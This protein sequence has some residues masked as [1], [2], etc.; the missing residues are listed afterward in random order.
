MRS[1]GNITQTASVGIED[2]QS[3][4]VSVV[5]TTTSATALMESVRIL[6]IGIVCLPASD[7]NAGTFSFTWYGERGPHNTETMIYSQ[8]VPSRWIFYPPEESL[9]SFWI[10][11][12]DDEAAV[13]LFTLGA[14]NATVEIIMDIHFE[15]V[16]L[17]GA[18]DKAFTLSSAATF[19]GIGA[20][21]LANVFNPVALS[22]VSVL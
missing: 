6:S 20:R 8:G 16:V 9:A 15:Y 17:D 21:I 12:S 5:D 1:S 19:T 2:M 4:L 10:N 13:S 3:M 18:R 7:T 14:D 11:A 22:G